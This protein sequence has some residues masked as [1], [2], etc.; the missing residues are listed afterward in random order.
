MLQISRTWAIIIAILAYTILGPS[1]VGL[2]EILP[3]IALVVAFPLA[4][5]YLLIAL[6]RS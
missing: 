3:Q 4:I 5:A 2:L 1:L 6:H